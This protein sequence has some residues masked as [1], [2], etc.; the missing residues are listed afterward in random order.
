MERIRIDLPH[1]DSIELNANIK[2][3]KEGW[4]EM[5]SPDITNTLAYKWVCAG[6]DSRLITKDWVYLNA[7]P[8]GSSNELIDILYSKRIDIKDFK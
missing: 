1:G 4:L 7:R 6:G 8:G 2:P 3:Q 5:T